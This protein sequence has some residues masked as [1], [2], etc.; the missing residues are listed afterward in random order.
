[1]RLVLRGRRLMSLE[2]A[3]A[4]RQ[5]EPS[6]Y[7]R[8]RM[9]RCGV[10]RTDA[11]MWSE[12]HRDLVF[13]RVPG[14]ELVVAD[15]AG[16]RFAVWPG[17]VCGR[18]S[19]CRGG[20]EHLCDEMKILGFHHDGGF[21]RE[22]VVPEAGLVPVPEIVPSTAACFAEPTGCVLHAI[23]KLRLRQGARIIIFGGGT[24]GLIAAL[25]CRE[26]GALPT[27]IE[28]SEKKIG[29]IRAFLRH[30]EVACVK[31]T[32]EGA[33]D[34][35]LNACPDPAAFSR[36]CRKAWQGRSLLLLQRLAP[37]REAGNEPGE[38]APLSGAGTA[39]RLRTPPFGPRAGPGLSSAGTLA[40]S[41]SSSRL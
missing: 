7:R 26:L 38:P 24:V 13:P 37:K 25:V 28:R 20:R 15:E 12:G 35:A 40:A 3:S 41:T 31:D 9:L 32:A 29:R 17:A 10:C 21:A 14:H 4:V 18:C 16:R 8:L 39:R 33:F 19:C 1:M 2:A 5:S 11:K 23:E 6:G 30:A 22:V 34:A 36:G 27:V